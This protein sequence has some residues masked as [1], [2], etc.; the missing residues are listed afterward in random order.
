MIC[1]YCLY[2]K[3]KIT[4]SRGSKTTAT[5]WRRHHCPNCQ[6]NF[7]TYETVEPTV[8]ITKNER[9][10][11]FSLGKLHLSI[12]ACFSHNPESAGGD[13]LELAK[14]IQTALL[15]KGPKLS[16]QQLALIVQA[17]LQN[18][19]S[20]AALQYGIKHQL[21]TSTKAKPGRPATKS[22]TI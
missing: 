15:S 3:T 5:V 13:S 21:I 19:D 11:P 18:F 14:T 17:R 16:S 7:S 4:N 1:P 6:T 9:Q 22:D 8:T 20:L 10:T 2:K 12:A